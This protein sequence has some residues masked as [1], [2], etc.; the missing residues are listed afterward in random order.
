MELINNYGRSECILS[1]GEAV[2]LHTLITDTIEANACVASNTTVLYLAAN[3][4]RH[5]LGRLGG[6]GG[7]SPELGD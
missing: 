6:F 1:Q 3:A 4:A 7:S 5:Y 2:A